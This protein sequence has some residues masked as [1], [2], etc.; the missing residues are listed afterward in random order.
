[1]PI[2]S[3][4]EELEEYAAQLIRAFSQ[5]PHSVLVES[6][7]APMLILLHVT[8]A[9]VDH[10]NDTVSIYTKKTLTHIINK[11]SSLHLGKG[12]RLDSH[13]RVAGE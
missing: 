6:T 4:T 9:Q 12:G 5:D 13:I 7:E 1:M 3:N 11:V 10:D 2:P 8:L